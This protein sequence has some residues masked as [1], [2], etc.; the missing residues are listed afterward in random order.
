MSKARIN[1][2][3]SLILSSCDSGP[4][5]R[6]YAKHTLFLHDSSTFQVLGGGL[7]SETYT[8]PAQFFILSG[9]D[10]GPGRRKHAGTYIIPA[11]FQ[12]FPDPWWRNHVENVHESCTIL[13]TSELRF[14]SRAA[15]ACQNM[16][17]SCMIP[18]LSRSL[19]GGSCR[20]HA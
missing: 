11:R 2:A 8:N 6:K 7:V 19:V 20:K 16:C 1:P 5:L 15:K 17:Y 4:G 13:D 10:S 9:Y 18:V 12:Y 3:Q 14:Q